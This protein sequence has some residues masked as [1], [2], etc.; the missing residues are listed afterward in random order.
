MPVNPMNA[1]AISPVQTKAMEDLLTLSF[2]VGEPMAELDEY[3]PPYLPV[4][5]SG[6]DI[7]DAY[8]FVPRFDAPAAPEKAHGGVLTM[9]FDAAPLDDDYHSADTDQDNVISLS[10][11]LRIIQLYNSDALHCDAAGED[12]YAPG[13]GDQGCESHASDYAP[14]DWSISLSELLRAIQLYNSDG[15]VVDPEGED[16]FDVV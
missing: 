15:Y 3:L 11:L 9:A 6:L 14:V 7:G 16:G 5:V 10:E 2:T 1:T 8:G 12:G 13:E 4:R